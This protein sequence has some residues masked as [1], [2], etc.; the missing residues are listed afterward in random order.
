MFIDTVSQN[1]LFVLVKNTDN[2]IKCD[3]TYMAFLF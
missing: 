3:K 1:V 2:C